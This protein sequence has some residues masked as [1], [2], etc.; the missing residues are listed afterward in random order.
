MCHKSSFPGLMTILLLCTN[1]KLTRDTIRLKAA[2]HSANKIQRTTLTM[3]QLKRSN[4]TC[5]ANRK[6]STWQTH[7]EARC[8]ERRGT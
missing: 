1:S 2:L 7:F 6:M 4:R 3:E 5:H 8:K